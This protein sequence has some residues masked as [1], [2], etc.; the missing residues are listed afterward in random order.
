[1][2][3][4]NDNVYQNIDK[5]VM[6]VKKYHNG[7]HNPSKIK[8]KINKDPLEIDAKEEILEEFL[9]ENPVKEQNK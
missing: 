7:S 3:Y 2:K 6:G 8:E 1:M 5:K 4:L 9:S